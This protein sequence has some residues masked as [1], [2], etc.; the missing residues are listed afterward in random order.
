M[1][2]PQL[3]TSSHLFSSLAVQPL[4]SNLLRMLIILLNVLFCIVDTLAKCAAVAR[5]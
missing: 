2:S 4:D 5:C 1:P 3:G